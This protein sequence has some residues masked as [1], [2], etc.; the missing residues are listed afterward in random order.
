MSS[1][2]YQSPVYQVIAVSFEKIVLNIGNPNVTAPPKM[3]LL[4]DS[5]KEDNYTM[6]IVCYYNK[7]QDQYVIIDGFHRYRVDE[8][9]S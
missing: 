9:I 7:Q 8:G 4:Y 5:I 1:K 6:S 2:S 3:K